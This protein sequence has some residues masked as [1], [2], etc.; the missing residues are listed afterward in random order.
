M[1]KLQPDRL[2]HTFTQNP[3]VKVVT[4]NDGSIVNT[5]ALPYASQP[6]GIAFAP[7]EQA[8]FVALQ[9][10]GR[11]L[12]LNPKTGELL[13]F[14]D[15]GPDP[16]GRTVDIRELAIKATSDQV[17]VARFISPDH[18]GMVYVVNASTMTLEN[19][20][21]LPKSEGTDGSLFARGLP[22]YLN[23][24][25]ISPDGTRAWIA[26]KKDNIDRGAQLDGLNLGHDNVVRAITPILDL[27]T[28][29]DLIEQ[30]IDYDNHDR[31]S[32]CTFS[33]RGDL[34]FITFPGNNQVQVV[35]AYS[36]SEI[37]TLLT[38]DVPIAAVLEN[39]SGKLFVLNFLGRSLS[40]FDVNPML[41]GQS[42]AN[43]IR[44]VPLVSSEPLPTN[45]LNGKKLFYNAISKALNLDGYMSCASCHID[46]SHDGRTY[47]FSAP[48]GEGLRNTIDLR[49]RAGSNHGRL[50]WTGNFDEVHD[51]ENQ[52]RLLGRGT[53]LMNNEDFILG[54]RSEPLGDPK[55]N[56]SDRL[57]DLAAY[58]HSLTEIPPSPYRQAN[59]F[60]TIEGL[61]GR[62]HFNRLRCYSCH[63]GETFTDSKYLSGALHNVGTQTSKSG[64][65]MGRPLNG[66]DT[67]SLLGVWATAPYLHDGS[68]ATLR[69]VLTT[70][71]PADQHGAVSNLSSE[72]I[73]ELI[74]YLK[75][76]DGNEPAALPAAAV[77]AEAFRQFVA[78]VG[79]T[80]EN[81]SKE[82]DP[83]ADGFS[84]FAEFA[85]GGTNP[86]DPRH[87]PEIRFSLFEYPDVN[88]LQ[89]SWLQ[90]EGGVWQDDLSYAWGDTIYRAEGSF[91]LKYWDCQL[92]YLPVDSDLPTS[93]SGFRWA[94][95]RIID[96]SFNSDKQFLRLRVES[97]E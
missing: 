11:L 86:T 52:I 22:N 21:L 75:Q 7:D 95:F 38:Q 45:V 10:L 34:V 8:A 70:R 57:D 13:D 42:N 43:F 81:A 76:I 32:S 37:N 54:D 4:A 80:D 40:V 33:N 65:R 91:D 5:I 82:A 31:C 18:A 49:G 53:G 94:T 64:Q 9:A 56:I 2:S 23:S 14:I 44:N 78:I 1:D 47:D 85:I 29:T 46:G 97:N 3:D 96:S 60:L 58:V 51:F 35:D 68:A 55:S 89:L 79:L 63:G 6:C 26:A 92:V 87:Y 67:P 59:G 17:Y 25:T 62:T 69:D 19:T 39:S 73:D 28:N 72:E 84:N 12:K 36:G 24:I 77:T 30:R 41:E 16:D 61:A 88:Y 93:P 90:R 20:I 83:D 74:A 15:L 66:F 71:N 48:M 27:T 50:H